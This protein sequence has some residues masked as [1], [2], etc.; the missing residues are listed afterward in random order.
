[1]SAGH[2]LRD[3]FRP[4]GKLTW[5][6]L[7]LIIEH[8]PQDSATVQAL[9]TEKDRQP[10]S[11]EALLLAA[12]EQAVNYNTYVN[13]G[14][15]AGKKNPIPPPKNIL[16]PDAGNDANKERRKTGQAPADQQQARDYLR[17]LRRRDSD[18]A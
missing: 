6:R 1:M 17:S 5:R 2:D 10:Y 14:L 11:M 18:S 4:S 8:L 9:R 15:Q 3:L 7:L 13:A 16:F 12:V